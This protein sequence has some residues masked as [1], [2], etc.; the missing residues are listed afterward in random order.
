MGEKQITIQLLSRFSEDRFP[1]VACHV[2][3]RPQSW[4]R[5]L[6]ETFGFGE[7][8]AQAPDR[9]TTREEHATPVAEPVCASR[10]T[11]ALRA[12]RMSRR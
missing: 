4:F 11:A 9:L 3:W 8:I 1:G 5:E 12:M 2:G 10:S 7:L 6:D